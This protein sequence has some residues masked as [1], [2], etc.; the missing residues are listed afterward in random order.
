M[1]ISQIN[2]MKHYLAQ[3]GWLIGIIFSRIGPMST[4]WK[5]KS[6]DKFLYACR[7]EF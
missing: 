2:D 3:R 4:P 7:K 5:R 6:F 1:S